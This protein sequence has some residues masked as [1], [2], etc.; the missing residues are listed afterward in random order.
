MK[1]G[2][3]PKPGFWKSPGFRP[4]LTT[5]LWRN[6]RNLPAYCFHGLWYQG[7]RNQQLQMQNGH[8]LYNEYNGSLRFWQEDRGFCLPLLFYQ[9]NHYLWIWTGQNQKPL[10]DL[11]DHIRH[12]KTKP[13]WFTSVTLIIGFTKIACRHYLHKKILRSYIF[14]YYRVSGC[15]L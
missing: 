14:P 12:P 7:L 5:G 15:K 2:L 8:T 1:P 3:E 4:P 6:I 10:I 9:R 13:C 11:E